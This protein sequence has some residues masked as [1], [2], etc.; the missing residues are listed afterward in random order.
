[1][2]DAVNIKPK[3]VPDEFLLPRDDSGGP[4]YEPHTGQFGGGGYVQEGAKAHLSPSGG[5]DR[6]RKGMN[7]DQKDTKFGFDK[8]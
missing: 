5:T 1:M 4:D 2:G 3:F 6:M 8:S 7:K